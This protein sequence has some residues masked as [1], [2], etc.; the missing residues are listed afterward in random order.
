MPLEL[1]GE[2]IGSSFAVEGPWRTL[3]IG[4]TST[5]QG[6][7]RPTR[8]PHETGSRPLRMGKLRMWAAQPSYCKNEQLWYR[9]SPSVETLIDPS[10]EGRIQSKQVTRNEWW[11][12]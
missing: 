5:S 4:I 9:Q 3:S 11:Q 2:L 12:A 8:Q 1:R 10:G 7:A 6:D